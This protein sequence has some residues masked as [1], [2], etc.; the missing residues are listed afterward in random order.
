MADVAIFCS[1]LYNCLLL[2]DGFYYLYLRELAE[3]EERERREREER[4]AEER[5]KEEEKY[6]Q[7]AINETKNIF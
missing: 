5:R 2:N 7:L 6:E 1:R 4:E 3:R